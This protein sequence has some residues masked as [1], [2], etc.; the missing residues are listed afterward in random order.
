MT[1]AAVEPYITVLC[2]PSLLEHTDATVMYGS[3]A[4]Y[5]T[6]RRNLIIEQPSC[7]SLIACWCSSSPL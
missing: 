3:E 1:T 5:D 4:F 7:T 2:A 6:C